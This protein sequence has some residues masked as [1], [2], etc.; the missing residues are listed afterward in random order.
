MA[1]NANIGKEN[2]ACRGSI[3]GHLILHQDP[4]WEGAK[5]GATEEEVGQGFFESMGEEDDQIAEGGHDLW[6]GSPANGGLIFAEG[7]VPSSME[8]IFYAPVV[9]PKAQKL[10]RRG[11]RGG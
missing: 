10:L 5:P 2:L 1:W 9:S 7:N 8:V 4:G 6:G 3:Q 11:I